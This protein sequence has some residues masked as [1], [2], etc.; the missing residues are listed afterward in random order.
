MKLFGEYLVEKEI[1]NKDALVKALI[2]QMKSMPSLAEIIF[3]HQM[4]S[5]DQLMAV[6]RLQT[7]RKIGFVEAALEAGFWTAELGQKVDAQLA[8][9]RIP[10][11]EILVK[12]GVASLPQISKALDEF[13]GE[14]KSREVVTA[15]IAATAPVV[16][17]APVEVAA[18][19]PVVEAVVQSAP[20]GSSTFSN[21]CDL[22]REDMKDSFSTVATPSADGNL[23][24]E[25]LK[26]V[27]EFVHEFRG[28]A[29][30]SEIQEGSRILKIAEEILE[31][32]IKKQTVKHE[33]DVL[34]KLQSVFPRLFDFLWAYQLALQTAATEAE[35]LAMEPIS[36]NLQNVSDSLE[37][38]KFDLGM[39]LI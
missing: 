26:T 19:A 36:K 9:V 33:P 2:Q 12:M 7:H 29:S 8:R 13:L 1:I 21:F 34:T 25:K 20:A 5:T 38:V 14:A 10:L 27:R 24:M 22:F 28:G 3:D 4:M 11:G 15:P 30:L 17:P 35:V 23:S 37:L 31:N 6:F 32:L 18:P 39:P 16:A